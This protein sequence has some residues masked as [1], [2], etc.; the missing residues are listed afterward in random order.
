MI[1][2]PNCSYT[3]DACGHEEEGYR[4][5]SNPSPLSKK[6]PKCGEHMSF[7]PKIHG[8]PGSDPDSFIH[9]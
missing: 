3:C 8:G 9:Y 7:S 5:D 6:C 1:S 2:Q 4:D